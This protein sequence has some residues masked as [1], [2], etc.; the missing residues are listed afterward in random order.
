MPFVDCVLFARPTRS[1]NLFLQML[2]RGLRLSPD[3]NKENCLLIDLVG[4]SASPGTLVCTPTLFGLDPSE[5]IDGTYAVLPYSNPCNTDSALFVGDTVD[6]LQRRGL[7]ATLSRPPDNG[8]S[9]AEPAV[10][11]TADSYAKR[12]SFHY[13][14]YET[15][16]DLVQQERKRG[17]EVYIPVSRLSRLAWVGVGEDVFVMDIMGAGHVKVS[18]EEDGSAS[19]PSFLPLRRLLMLPF[20]SSLSSFPIS[21]FVFAR[22]LFSPPPPIAA[23]YISKLYRRIPTTPGLPRFFPK[24]ETLASHRSLPILLKTTDATI[25]NNPRYADLSLARHASWRRKEASPAQLAFLTKKLGKDVEEVEAS[26]SASGENLGAQIGGAVR[27]AISGVWVGKPYKQRIF[28]DDLTKGQASDILVR[29]MHGGLAG[30]RSAEKGL[31]R[32]EKKKNKEREK[33]EKRL[34]QIRFK[35]NAGE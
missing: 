26:P 19:L 4:N 1:Q 18:K 35:S 12:H 28:V 17:G 13:R 8:T 29:L 16:F 31:V 24:A 32:E 22:L 11:L 10:K 33:M 34:S 15:A 23:A 30:W 5:K 14:D 7:E 25:L 3:T 2:G 21:H 6:Q 27:Q 9:A 20:A